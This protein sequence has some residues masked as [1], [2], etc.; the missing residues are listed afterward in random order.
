MTLMA[1]PKRDMFL[2]LNEE[3]NVAKLM[4]DNE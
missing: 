1:E 4:R 2:T 3:P